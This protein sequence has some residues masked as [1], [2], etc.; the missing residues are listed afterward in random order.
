MFVILLKGFIVLVIHKMFKCTFLLN[1]IHFFFKL[2]KFEN[3][4]VILII[5]YLNYKKKKNY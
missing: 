1:Y 2:L 5:I 3:K 4:F